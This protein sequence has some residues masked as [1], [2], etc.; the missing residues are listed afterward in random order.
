MTSQA[1]E[2]LFLLI[3]KHFLVAILH[4]PKNKYAENGQKMVRFFGV[5]KEQYFT[6]YVYEQNLFV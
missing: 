3:F 2:M 4:Q 1:S 5:Q 6:V